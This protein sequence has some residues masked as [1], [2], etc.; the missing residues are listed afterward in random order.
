MTGTRFIKQE[1]HDDPSMD[2]DLDDGHQ[3]KRAKLDT[4]TEANNALVTDLDDDDRCAP[5]YKVGDHEMPRL[6]VYC[7][8]FPDLLE[9]ATKPIHLVLS[10]I[11]K[12]RDRPNDLDEFLRTSKRGT[13]VD[14]PN[15]K[16]VATLGE[17]GKGK[18]STLIS[19]S[20]TQGMA[21]TGN[22]GGSVTNVV[23]E[24]HP[25]RP[26]QTKPF[27]VE[28]NIMNAEKRNEIVMS[29][30][31]KC[32][33]VFTNTQ[34]HGQSIST[35]EQLEIV[36]EL[37]AEAR[38]GLQ[39]LRTLFCDRS[40][41]S[42]DEKA[43]I[44][45]RKAKSGSDKAVG[46]KF[47]NWLGELTKKHG[48]R[49]GVVTLT[50]SD[51]QELSK[52]VEPYARTPIIDEDIDEEPSLWPIVRIIRIYSDAPVL[53]ENLILADLPGTSD[54]NQ[55]RVKATHSYLSGCDAIMLVV[56]MD[57]VVDKLWLE[58]TLRKFGRT[59]KCFLVI[60]KIDE[61]S[62]NGED[63]KMTAALR[64]EIEVLKIAITT[65]RQ[66]FRETTDVAVKAIVRTKLKRLE[67]KKRSCCIAAR[68]EAVTK[69]LE[70][71]YRGKMNLEIFCVSNLEYE[72]HK[73]GYFMED[74][75]EN[76]PK[77]SVKETGI[78]SLRHRLFNFPARSRYEAVRFHVRTLIPSIL[79]AGQIMCLK[80]KT[81]RKDTIEP[82]VRDPEGTC[83]V[84]FAKQRDDLL[85]AMQGL[86]QATRQ[87][88][89]A[90]RA[91][92]VTTADKWAEQYK[93]AAYNAFCKNQGVRKSPKKKGK[94][95]TGDSVVSWNEQL[96]LP[97]AA[98]LVDEFKK[99]ELATLKLD[100]DY[101]DR[102]DANSIDVVA[103]LQA[104]HES[105]LV[106]MPLLIKQQGVTRDL[107]KKA[108]TDAGEALRQKLSLIGYDA[109]VNTEGSYL[110][111]QMA[112]VYEE[113]LQIR[114][115]NSHA[116]RTEY[117]RS[118]IRGG[119]I[120]VGKSVFASIPNGI[121]DA[122]TRAIHDYHDDLRAR[123]QEPLGE[124]AKNFDNFFDDNA[125]ETDESKAFRKKTT[126]WIA[127]AHEI[128][129]NE[130]EPLLKA[131]E[132]Y[133]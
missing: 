130:V 93:Y 127:A 64:R 2:Q 132:N 65:A 71:K 117:M 67:A 9:A 110:S 101:C 39:T 29:C 46:T 66:E 89:P 28:I 19:I 59:K 6:A 104:Q 86:V 36:Q 38:D 61:L 75:D 115:K 102:I 105:L 129:D 16:I 79:N 70:A 126:E 50:A 83:P 40:E 91:H 85:N 51:T 81:K 1:L 103:K 56:T 98:L 47:K 90:W 52:L 63:Q 99:L 25:S 27:E 14:M 80:S 20:D 48:A 107:T 13:K 35:A 7:P 120:E 96:L 106:P 41:F 122:A 17:S 131:C 128:L 95:L 72:K 69:A 45:V 3:H 114:G 10:E 49:D 119:N 11:K 53:K 62:G 74:D 60:T 23:H 123:A 44:F 125:I 84:L 4:D 33:A 87:A 77:L 121:Q 124:L 22:G 26:N 78:P 68:N 116:N 31:S 100:T 76:I 108:V 88:L 55:L 37:E 12:A 5:P 15:A 24:Y 21:F 42:S 92:G 109:Y 112:N 82:I 54:T 118:K 57:R 32:H 111:S 8:Q 113:I 43:E 73:T 34:E 133:R 58:Q 94:P 18:S 30:F 97:V